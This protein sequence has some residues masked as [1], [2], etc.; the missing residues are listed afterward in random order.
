M[1]ACYVMVK[2]YCEYFIEDKSGVNGEDAVY[3]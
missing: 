2:Y 3:E 1:V